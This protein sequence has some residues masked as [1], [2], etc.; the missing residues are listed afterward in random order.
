M[1]TSL[2][3]R[4]HN[5]KPRPFLP[6]LRLPLPIGSSL[7]LVT[8]AAAVTAPVAAPGRERVADGALVAEAAPVGRAPSTCRA[9]LMIRARQIWECTSEMITRYV[10]TFCWRLT[11]VI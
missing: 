4:V 5:R 11:H 8:P 7:A 1:S 2:L 10:T 6:H 9:E 3:A